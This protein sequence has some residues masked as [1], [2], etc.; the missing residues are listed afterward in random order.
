MKKWMKFGTIREIK[1]EDVT[2]WQNK[3][4]P[5]FDIDWACDEVLADTTD[6]VEEADVAATWFV[7]HDTP[8]LKPTFNTILKA[9]PR[10]FWHRV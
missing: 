7:T 1:V 2:T 4:F 9:P 10:I 8:L 6:L 3:V 5:T